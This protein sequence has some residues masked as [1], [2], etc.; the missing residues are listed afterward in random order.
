MTLRLRSSLCILLLLPELAAAAIDVAR[1]NRYAPEQGLSQSVVQAIT[2][3]A[4]GFVWVGTQQGLNRFDGHRF[5]IYRHDP[6]DPASLSDDWIWALLL[7]RRDR[8]WVGTDAGGLQLLDAST[9]AV[10]PLAELTAQAEGLATLSVRVLAE[11]GLGRIWFGTDGAGVGRLEPD[12]GRLR[13]FDASAGLANDRVKALHIGDGGFVWVGTDGGGLQR[14]DPLSNDVQSVTVPGVSRIRSLA[15]AAGGRLWIGSQESGLFRF[16]PSSGAVEAFDGTRLPKPAA[17][18]IR[19]LMVDGRGRLWVATDSDGVSLFDPV[20]GRFRHLRHQ[21][22]DPRSLNDDHASALFED[23][24][25]V[26]WVGTSIGLNTWNPASGGFAT[27]ARRADDPTSLASNWVAGFADAPSPGT[28]NVVYVATVGGGVDRVQLD[29]GR[30]ESLGDDGLSDDRVFALSWAHGSLWAGTR[31]GGLNRY[32]PERGHWR[33]YRHAA[34]R[35]DSLAADGVT[36]LATDSRGRLWIGTYGGGLDRYDPGSDGFVHYRADAA[37]AS[38]LCDD[39][40]LALLPVAGDRLWVGTHGGGLCRLNVASGRFVTL[41]HDPADA[42]SLSGDDAWALAEDSS[43]NLWIGTAN[44]GLNRFSA[45]ARERFD[46]TGE[47]RLDHIGRGQGLPSPAVTALLADGHGNVWVAHNRGLSRIDADLAM[48]HY[49]VADGL[50]GNE[51]N[52]GAAHRLADGR[53]LFGGA[54]GFN[55]FYP[56]RVGVN[57]HAPP[58]AFTDIHLN[59]EAVPRVR[60]ASPGEGLRLDH[61]VRHLLVAFAALDFTDPAS[62]RYRH[63]L[64]GFDDD[65]IDDGGNRQLSWTNLAPGDYRLEVQG[66][67]NEGVWSAAV[68]RLPIE[69]LPAPWATWWAQTL[70]ALAVL[71]LLAMARAG[72]ERRLARAAEH[73]RMQAALIDEMTERERRE[74]ELA[75]A[76]ERA[77]RYLDVVEVVILALDQDGAITL[78]NQKGARLL[79]GQESDIVG[80]NFYEDYVPAGSRDDVRRHF[81]DLEQYAYSESPVLAGD[82]SERLVAWHAIALTAR[83]EEGSPAG[84]LISGSDITQVRKLELQLRESQKMEALG[85][86]ARGVAHDFNNIL[87]A[88]L[89]YAE[90]SLAEPDNPAGTDRYLRQLTRSVDRARDLVQRILSFSRGG[91]QAPLPLNLAEVVSEAVELM[92]PMLGANLEIHRDLEYGCGAVLADP[93]QL[94]QVVVNLCTNASQAIGAGRG[95]IWLELRQRDLDVEEARSTAALLPGPHVE[96]VV[97]DDGPGM[98]DYTRARIFDPFFTTRHRDDG[99]GLGLSVVR[100]IIHQLKGTVSVDSTPG[101]GTR[102]RILLPCVDETP[103]TLGATPEAQLDDAGGG[104]TVLIVDDEDPVRQI[105]EQSLSAAGY[106]VLLARE[107]A[108]ALRL[109]E[110]RGGEVDLII[111]DQTMPGLQGHELAA[112][113]Q[114]QGSHIP[115]VLISG[116]EPPSMEGVAEFI[117]KPYS[118]AELHR[119]VRAVLARVP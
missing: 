89:G 78:V 38:T 22:A 106:R 64:V 82:G 101:Q 26:I 19:D 63:R 27:Y 9:G 71:A 109:L 72:Y 50:Q 85:T 51:F 44:A 32:D 11:D 45:E 66:A 55:A 115:L 47:V 17:D 8:L 68:L 41:R 3:D 114:A 61:R 105:A 116:T 24:G 25:G 49:T 28:G 52:F 86:L 87:S 31:A 62:N 103:V 58:V 59:Y 94:V 112:T 34:D 98:D 100:G 33:A 1:F 69:V 57:D 12:T 65:W 107:G 46:T 2:Q 60:W 119:V 42:A 118:L 48:R 113:L 54:Q 108:D 83:R 91:S 92:R 111:T 30:A 88:I 37:D 40:V 93:A 36:S 23:R 102:F 21:P 53:L 95:N 18:A 73:S 15:G 104:E 96:L 13:M 5:E 81:A 29:S 80:R 56:D 70:Y 35:A 6:E 110:H 74:Q 99:T 76:R 14:I 79:G 84:A 10:V 97:A 16:D 75:V 7:D 20:D 4:E 67:N 43:G 90:L 117:A 39:R 77:Q